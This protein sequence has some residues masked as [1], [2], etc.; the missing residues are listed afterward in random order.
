MNVEVIKSELESR[1]KIVLDWLKGDRRRMIALAT[2]IPI[3]LIY[4]LSKGNEKVTYVFDPKNKRNFE[5]EGILENPYKTI[6]Q[7]KLGLLEQARKDIKEE[8]KKLRFELDQLREEMM[9]VSQR[10]KLEESEK[11]HDEPPTET[12][13]NTVDAKPQNSSTDSSIGFA[14]SP[15]DGFRESQQNSPIT[16]S[17]KKIKKRKKRIKESLSHSRLVFPVKAKTKEEEPGV[18]LG[19]GSWALGTIIAGAEIPQQSTYPILIQLDQAYTMASKKRLSLVGCL[20]VAKA[21]TV[22]STRHIEIQ[23]ESMGCFSQSGRYFE[24]KQING[25]GT[26]SLDNN[27]GVK[28]LFRSNV[29]RLAEYSFI[30]S[31]L[32]GAE[33]IIARQSKRVG[34]A[35][36]DRA[37]VVVKRGA[38]SSATMVADFLMRQAKNLL[39]TLS[40][41]SGRKVYIVMKDSVKLP[42]EFFDGKEEESEGFDYSFSVFN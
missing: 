15:L 38:A 33:D 21:S 6:Y 14:K 7:G 27:F 8:N 11:D 40:V 5:Q 26:D 41:N 31:L 24:K 2:V 4:L 28:G 19:V 37:D 3:L 32:E 18:V 39:P 34:G 42:Y 35:D 20:M 22:M 13:G 16:E 10:R 29:T 23:P 30:K 25:W 12:K 17:S 1:Y 9:Q 36:P